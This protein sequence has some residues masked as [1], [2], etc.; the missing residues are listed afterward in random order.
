MGD[1][2]DLGGGDPGVLGQD[3]ER[4]A[5]ADEDERD[6]PFLIARPR[7]AEAQID[8]A[9][10]GA[11]ARND[12]LLDDL[13]RRPVIVGPPGLQQALPV[14]NVREYGARGDG[15]GDDTAAIQ[16][17]LD[18]TGDGGIVYFPY[19]E[20]PVQGLHLLERSCLTLLGEGRCSVVRRLAGDP[21]GGILNA[22]GCVDLRI[23]RL[24]FDAVGLEPR[25]PDDRETGVLSFRRCSG[26]SI[27]EVVIDDTAPPELPDFTGSFTEDRWRSGLLFDQ[28]DADEAVPFQANPD[29]PNSN[30]RVERCRFRQLGILLRNAKDVEVVS[31]HFELVAGYAVVVGGR[32]N[33]FRHSDVLVRANVIR[34]PQVG[35]IAVVATGLDARVAPIQLPPTMSGIRFERIR[36]CENTI[37]KSGRTGVPAWRRRWPDGHGVFVGLA[38]ERAGLASTEVSD[39]VIRDVVVRENH[40]EFERTSEWPARDAYGIVFAFNKAEAGFPLEQEEPVFRD[41]WAEDPPI[42]AAPF[43]DPPEPNYG[44]EMF[45]DGRNGFLRA[46][47]RDNTIVGARTHA[48]RAQRFSRCTIMGNVIDGCEGAVHLDASQFTTIAGNVAMTTGPYPYRSDDNGWFNRGLINTAFPRHY[49]VGHGYSASPHQLPPKMWPAVWRLD[50]LWVFFTMVLDKESG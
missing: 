28:I 1:G 27:D 25:D 2:P 50:H 36:I 7:G 16:E 3:L 39:V 22:V 13:G 12:I 47:I 43:V 37:L 6:E 38:E 15:T 19:G 31:N 24:A 21:T 49:E 40:V 48:I 32:G 10:F 45:D 11:G 34:N 20:Y 26:V 14:T 4:P 41:P 42:W 5:I 44:I 46:S 23:L 35:G 17:A 29:L 8:A 33:G 9:M 18:R 30:V